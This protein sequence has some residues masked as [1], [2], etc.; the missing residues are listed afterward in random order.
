MMV[1]HHLEDDTGISY[2][3]TSRVVF[4]AIWNYADYSVVLICMRTCENKAWP[5]SKTNRVFQKN[6]TEW[7]PDKKSL[8]SLANRVTIL[9]DG[10]IYL[11]KLSV[12][13]HSGSGVV[14]TL[15]ISWL[16]ECHLLSLLMQTTFSTFLGTGKLKVVQN[17]LFF[18]LK[19]LC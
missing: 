13:Y 19:S 1:H 16:N 7:Y 10:Y 15:F 17:V 3:A 5:Q 6:D 18:H 2:L 11:L 9:K 4:Q 14:F 12:F 8:W